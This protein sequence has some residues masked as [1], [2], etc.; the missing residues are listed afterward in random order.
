VGVAAA[1]ACVATA[2]SSTS[3]SATPETTTPPPAASTS[4]ITSQAAAS[5]PAP[6][7][8]K[9]TPLSFYASEI[10]KNAAPSDALEAKL[11]ALPDDTPDSQVQALANQLVAAIQSENAQ[12]LRMSWP[13]NIMADIKAMVVA[14]GP[15]L[16]DFADLES[17]QDR[18]VTDSGAANAAYNILLADVGLPPVS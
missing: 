9:P 3:K 4:A 13:A 17:G 12:L 16:G 7:S 11:K 8:P 18:L 2:C 15:V 5:P 14:D 6:S 10:K 1:T